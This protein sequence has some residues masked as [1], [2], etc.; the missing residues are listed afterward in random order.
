MKLKSILIFILILILLATLLPI[1]I[2]A[3][4][5]TECAFEDT[6]LGKMI[7]LM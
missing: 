4:Q 6:W 5:L 1:V 3:C 7:A 2:F